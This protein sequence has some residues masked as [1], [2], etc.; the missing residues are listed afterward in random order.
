MARIKGESKNF[1]DRTWD[2]MLM[3]QDKWLENQRRGYTYMPQNSE[4]DMGE[5]IGNA[6][7]NAGPL[8]LRDIL[9][10]IMLEQMR[11]KRKKSE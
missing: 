5:K 3:A 1:I 7:E 11:E 8:D 6:V 2:T 4:V 9:F 10:N